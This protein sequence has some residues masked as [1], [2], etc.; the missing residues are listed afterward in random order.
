LQFWRCD[1]IH[2]GLLDPGRAAGEPL[3]MCLALPGEIV[4][5]WEA[6]LPMARV[7]FGAVLREVCLAYLPEAVPGD[8]VIVHVG[9]AIARLDRAAAEATLEALAALPDADPSG[10]RP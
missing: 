4:E 1:V 10:G 7:R 3:S 9:F 6:E 2:D 5:R 8:W